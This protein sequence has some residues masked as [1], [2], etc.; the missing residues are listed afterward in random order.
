MPLEAKKKT[1]HP[2]INVI[3]KRFSDLAITAAHGDPPL[4]RNS[5]E[6]TCSAGFFVHTRI[7]RPRT[8]EDALICKPIFPGT[9]PFT[10]DVELTFAA[11]LVGPVPKV[12]ALFC[13]VFFFGFEQTGPDHLQ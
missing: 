7:S 3:S 12:D 10:V 4:A 1:I 11:T 9:T 8:D 5:T 6:R 13:F 2:D